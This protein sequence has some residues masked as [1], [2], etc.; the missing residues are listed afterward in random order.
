MTRDKS[1]IAEHTAAS[2]KPSKWGAPG[3]LKCLSQKV[4]MA[5]M[6]Q[7]DSELLTSLRNCRVAP[8]ILTSQSEDT[9]VDRPRL[10]TK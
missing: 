5:E 2:H 4:D 7:R 8:T 1:R 10:A 6:H 9:L 3:G